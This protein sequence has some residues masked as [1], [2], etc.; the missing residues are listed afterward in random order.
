VR[1]FVQR[2]NR[3]NGTTVILTTH[4]MDDIEALCSRII[5]IHQGSILFDGTVD[6]LRSQVTN[7][8]ELII[9]LAEPADVTDPAALAVARDGHR[10]RIRFD[11]LAT[12]AA[13][14]IARITARYAVAD[15]M[16]ENPPIEQIVARLYRQ[17]E[18]GT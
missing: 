1:D 13:E 6:G 17:L 7:E 18:A 15:L 2:K 9:D 4:D 8:R 14:L 5:L 11:P 16:V 12:P 10:V 3:Q